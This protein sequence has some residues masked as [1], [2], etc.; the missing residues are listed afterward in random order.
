M[1]KKITPEPLYHLSHGQRGSGVSISHKASAVPQRAR[2]AVVFCF[3]L[4]DT[5][6]VE[7]SERRPGGSKY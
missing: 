7:V 3:S 6:F 4:A 5:G 1:R 2:G